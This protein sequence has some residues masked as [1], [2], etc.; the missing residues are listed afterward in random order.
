MRKVKTINA[1]FLTPTT[2]FLRLTGKSKTILESIPRDK[3]QARFSIIATNPVHECRYQDGIFS[4]DDRSFATKDPLK[5]LEEVVIKSEEKLGDL[6]FNGGAIGYVGYD[7]FACYEDIGDLPD[8]EIGL[9]DLRFLLFESFVIFDHM[10]ETLTI[11]EENTY[12][13]RSTEELE[14]AIERVIKEVK[15]AQDS[16]FTEVEIDKLEYTSNMSQAE[17]EAIVNRTKE[18]IHQGDMFQM[19]P[20]QRLSADFPYDPFEYYRRLRVSNPSSYLYFIDF[21]DT[22]IIGSSPESLVSL[23]GDIVTTNPIAGTRRRGKTEAE[24]NELSSELLTDEKEL[25]EHKMLVDLGRNDIG[26]IS[27][28]GSVTVPL[29]LAIEKYR[30]VM[31][32][33]SLVQGKLKAGLSA[34]DAL[35]ALLPAGT[36]S[37]A[38]KIR[39]MQRIYQFE[40]VKRG[41]YAGAVGYLSQDDNCDFAI[42]IRTMVVKNKKAYVQAG[43]GIVFDSIAENEYYET[44]QKA[45]ATLEVGTSSSEDGK[46]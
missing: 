42:A 11:V 2:V 33:V 30:Y 29:Y 19:V 37:G 10:K 6:P 12:S 9:P 15:T 16:E 20:S 27:E 14:R 44:L 8:D 17:Y 5:A 40:K 31:H 4:Q 36:V 13:N 28:F 22:Q 18:Y 38:P 41:V 23:K 24:D 26:K 39:A 7:V 1:D 25:S 34:M 46:E 3:E 21:G 35:K 45:K 32:I 43:A